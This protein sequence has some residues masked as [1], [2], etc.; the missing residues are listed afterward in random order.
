MWDGFVSFRM[1]FS[2]RLLKQE[3]SHAELKEGKFIYPLRNIAVHKIGCQ[4]I[5]YTALDQRAGRL[6]GSCPRAPVH[7]GCQDVIRINGNTVLVTSGFRPRKNLS[8]KLPAF[9]AHAIKNVHQPCLRSKMLIKNIGLY[10]A[11]NY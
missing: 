11:P 5:T 6:P 7:T 4:L 2:C 10:W 3:I 8:E 1:G 9:R